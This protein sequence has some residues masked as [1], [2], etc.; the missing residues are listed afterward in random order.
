MKIY[1]LTSIAWTGFIEFVFND[2]TL[3]EKW[4]NHAE[5][6]EGQQVFLLKNLPREIPELEK[7]KTP[8]T[9]ITEIKEVITFTMFWDRYDDKVNSSRFKTERSW[10]KMTPVDQSRAFHFIPRYFAHIPQG[11]RKKYATT[12]LSDQLWNN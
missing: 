5:L 1:H 8:N 6:S 2:N 4:E 3:L 10:N 11:T 7:L 9:K 12:Y